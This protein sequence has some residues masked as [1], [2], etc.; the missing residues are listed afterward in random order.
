MKPSRRSAGLAKYLVTYHAAGMPQDPE[1]VAAARM[2][3]VQWAAK[4][5]MALADPGAPIRS[6]LVM[7]GD[8][9]RNGWVAPPFLGWS[10][11]EARDRNEAVRVLQ[12]NPLLGLGCTLQIS[13]LIDG[14]P[15]MHTAA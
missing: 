10:V 6:V 4:A 5:G 15:R 13:E 8:G 1:S 9:S 3:F 12:G 2:A 11:I 7:S 14:E